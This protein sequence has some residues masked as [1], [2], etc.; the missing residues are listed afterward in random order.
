[1][2]EYHDCVFVLRSDDLPDCIAIRLDVSATNL[3]RPVNIS[4]NSS[5]P[6][7]WVQNGMA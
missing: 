2:R 1:M 4:A 7:Y 3:P 5:S 6:S